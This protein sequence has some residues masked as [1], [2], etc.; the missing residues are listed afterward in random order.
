MNDSEL[1]GNINDAVRDDGNL[2]PNVKRQIFLLYISSTIRKILR[3]ANMMRFVKL[4]IYVRFI[5]LKTHF[6]DHLIQ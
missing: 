5:Y 2:L 6:F 4:D 3:N 1:W